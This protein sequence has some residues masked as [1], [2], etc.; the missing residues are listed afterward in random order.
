VTADIYE[1][2]TIMAIFTMLFA[3]LLTLAR[4]RTAAASSAGSEQ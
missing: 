4:L 1:T 2:A 3:A